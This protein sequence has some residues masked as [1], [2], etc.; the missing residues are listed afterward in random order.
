M[1]LLSRDH[2]VGILWP[3]MDGDLFCLSFNGQSQGYTDSWVGS[4]AL[5]DNHGLSDHQIRTVRNFGTVRVSACVM[6]RKLCPIST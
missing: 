2:E 3:E 5:G 1:S 4:M 6:S